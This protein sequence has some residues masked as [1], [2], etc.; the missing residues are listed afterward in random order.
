[1]NGYFIRSQVLILFYVLLSISGFA[2]S[3][4]TDF[5]IVE[6]FRVY[7][8]ANPYNLLFVHT[9]KTMYTNNETIWLSAYLVQSS[10]KPE[11]HTILSTF[12]I[13]QEDQQP[14]M[15][16]QFLMADALSFGSIDLPDSI[17][18]G[19]YQLL[20]YTNVLDGKGEPM[21]VFRQPIT[22]KS[23]TQNTF[24][25]ELVLMD[26]IPVNDMIR[27][28]VTLSGI[29][30]PK[31]RFVITYGIGKEKSQEKMLSAQERSYVISI[32]AKELA[33]PNPVLLTAIKANHEIQ[34]LSLK[35]P[36]I[37]PRDIQVRF[38]PASGNLADQVSSVVAWEAQTAE[39][40]PLAIEG[41]LYQDQQP[42][43]TIT[44]NIYGIGNFKLKPSKEKRYTVRIAANDYLKKDS[45]F[46]IPAVQHTGIVVDL[47]RVVVNDTLK[48]W[49]YSKNLQKV[50]VVVH[51][52]RQAYAS[53]TVTAQAQGAPVTIALP[54]VPKGIATISVLDDLGKPLAERLFFAHYDQQITADIQTGKQHHSAKQ[55]VPMNIK[56]SDQHGM[57]V[58][59]IMSVAV[60]QDN[61]LESGK[62]QDIETYTYL[63]HDLG[64]LPK[65][66]SG[67]GFRNKT[68]VEDMLIV[69]G[70][71][72]YTWNDLYRS[73][74]KDTL[75]GSTVTIKGRILINGKPLR[76]PVSF[77]IIKDSM[78]SVHTTGPTGDF[79]LG[80]SDITAVYGTKVMATVNEKN[81]EGYTIEVDNPFSQISRQLAK[82]TAVNPA[83]I[84][85]RSQK[86][87]RDNQIDGLQRIIALQEVVVRDNSNN[88]SIYGQKPKG[89]NECGDYVDHNGYLN[90][91]FSANNLRNTPPVLGRTYIDPTKVSV[92]GRVIDVSELRK[93]DI[94]KTVKIVYNGCTTRHRGMFQIDG[95]YLSKDFY[96]SGQGQSAPEVYSHQSTLDWKTGVVTAKDGTFS[97]TF[98]TGEL[99][100]K[101]RIIIQGV[102]Q[103]DTFYSEADFLVK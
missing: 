57:P 36:E 101:F 4:I 25:A 50:H 70:W 66:P 67:K 28:K 61:R 8:K 3:A 35:L 5:L 69:K 77:S 86:S 62:Q 97:T 76:K 31:Q 96:N 55:Q 46:S 72:R 26:T 102:G 1:M 47:P 6:K 81:R 64:P 32:P 43:D 60:I 10:L 63:Q 42:I 89:S 88:S 80:E 37:T 95:V 56:L 78:I 58:Q 18:P 99:T 65:D 9:D 14:V 13:R 34:Y 38:F 73:T 11:K 100:G 74:P 40:I 91:S 48:L 20:A 71:R 33:Q 94:F 103:S 85:T 15:Q 22:I 92:N 19:N 93:D 45:V 7:S 16:N 59:A 79:T 17:K 90:A 51:N 41:I 44:T 98:S 82:Q 53:F 84:I 75:G 68:Y 23:I 52:Y 27:T 12:L 30:D 29:N 54:A 2:Q 24:A 39:G 49:L 87:T 83:G 21:A